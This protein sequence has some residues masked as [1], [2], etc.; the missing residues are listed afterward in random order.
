MKDSLFIEKITYNCNKKIDLIEKSIARYA[1]RS[2]FAGAAL[3]M[4]TLAGVVA[5]DY[6]NTIH[7]NLGK[8]M[9]A[10]LFSW[11]LIYILFL[12]AELAT[13]NMMYL[14]AG[15]YLRKIKF[16]KAVKILLVCTFFNLV[17]AAA[18]GILV[19]NTS[20]LHSLKDTSM[21][22][23][24]VECKLAHSSSEIM[25]G[26]ILAN[27]FVNI[28]IIAFMLVKDENAKVGIILSAIFM[29]VYLG[30]DHV[31]ANFGSFSLVGFSQYGK[32]VIGLNI[33]NV[34][35]QWTFAF[36]GNL[37]GGGLILGFGYAW[38]NNKEI[39]YKD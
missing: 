7:P 8:F 27:V 30:L 19:S 2:I 37:V 23:K 14:T 26:G 33:V 12:N 32:N 4:T 25:S 3:A 18:I 24:I 20:V 13:S 38:L 29:F 22:V 10:F 21:L 9:Y 35:R 31:I 16:S 1:L 11:G 28:A 39:V 6:L 34:I 36:L 15:T 17:G 5:A